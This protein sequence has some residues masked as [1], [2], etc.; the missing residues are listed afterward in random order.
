V[1]VVETPPPPQPSQDELEA[2]IEEARRRTR[3]RRLAFIGGAL[4]VALAVG[5]ALIIGGLVGGG[6]G[7]AVPKGFVAVHSRGPVLHARLEDLNANVKTVALA[8]GSVKPTRVTREVWWNESTGLYRTVYRY[9]GVVI[10]DLVQ[11]GC[12]TPNRRICMPPEPF[13]LQL[14]GRGWPPRK[15]YARRVGTG[16][17]RGRPVVWVEGLVSPENGTH[18]LSGDQVGYDPVTHRPLVLRQILRTGS[19]RQRIFSQTAVTLLPVLSG[20]AVTFAVPDGGAP[21]NADLKMAGFRKVSIDEAANVL[22]RTP[23]WLG[24]SYKGHHLRFIQSGQEGSANGKNRGA[25]MAP[26]IR[27]DYGPFRLEEFGDER[28]VWLPGGLPSA[29]VFVASGSTTLERDGMAVDVVGGLT[30]PFSPAEA[31]ALARALRPAP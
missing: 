29:K 13:D 5:V 25:G 21:R 17:F 10:G 15:N 20:K 6:S 3:R 26:V 4:G 28:P 23:L 12:F 2:L 27:L 24:R 1:T 22:G 18:Q 9:D 31:A 19:G 30:G 16:T 7:T 11:D 8:D 14:K